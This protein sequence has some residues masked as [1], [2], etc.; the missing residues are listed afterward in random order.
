MTIMKVYITA[1]LTLLGSLQL[2]AQC[3]TFAGSPQSLVFNLCEGQ[4]FNVSTLGDEV[5]GGPCCDTLV[6]VVHTGGPVSLGTVIAANSAAGIPPATG[7]FEWSPAYQSGI[8]YQITAVAGLGDGNGPFG[9]NLTDPCLS[10]SPV[11]T[12]TYYPAPFVDAGPDLDLTCNIP[13]HVL[14]PVVTVIP[15]WQYSWTGP[16][17]FNSNLLHPTVNVPGN[18]CITVAD[19]ITG[20][21]ATD[22]M[23]VAGSVS[24]PVVQMSSTIIPC[25]G[26]PL[27]LDATGSSAGP[28][29]TYEWTQAGVGVVGTDITLTIPNPVPAFFQFI[30]TDT[31]TGCSNYTFFTTSEKIVADITSSDA[32]CEPG[33]YELPILIAVNDPPYL[34]SVAENGGAPVDY[35]NLLDPLTG[36]A[37]VPFQVNATT[38]FS[39]IIEDGSN[40][41]DTFF[42]TVYVHEGSNTFTVTQNGCQ[43]TTVEV[44]HQSVPAS[45]TIF[46][47]WST[48]GVGPQIEVTS[49]GWYTVSVT[50]DLGCTTVDSAFVEVDFTGQCAAI[51]G[52]VTQDSFANCLNDA[53][54]L[55]LA[56]WLVEAVGQDTF[57]ATTDATGFYAMPVDPGNYLVSV[58]PPT[59]LW[60]PCANGA[61]VDVPVAGDLETVDFLVQP[62]PGCLELLVNICTPF[63]RRCFSNY[64]FFSYCNQGVETATDAYVVVDLDDFMTFTS[65]SLPSSDLGNNQYQF[66]VGDLEPGECGAFWMEVFINCDAVLGQTHCTAA[67]IYPD[68]TCVPNDP[69]WS[70]ASLQVVAACADDSLRFTVTNVGTS[71]SMPLDFVVIEDAVMYME[72][73]PSPV[74]DVD[75]SFELA[76]PANGSTWRMEVQQEP[77]HP[78]AP[79]PV[80][81]VEGC[82]ENF[83]TGFINQFPLGDEPPYLDIDCT[84]N[85]GSY[86]PNDKQGFPV[87]YGDEHQVLPGTELQYLVRFQNTGTDTAFQVVIR[88]T[89]S[90]LLDVATV[91]PGA[92]SHPYQFEVYA[93][94]VLRFSFPD[95]LLPDSS[96][97]QA[98]S[99]GFVQFTVSPRADVPLG[100]V[101]ENTA[102]IYFD[103]NEPVITN[104]VFHT[105]DTNFLLANGVDF[106]AAGAKVSVSPNPFGSSVAVEVTG[107]QGSNLLTF[108]LSDIWGRTLAT[109]RFS[110][111]SFVF[112][113]SKL[114]VG[115]YFFKIADHGRTVARGRVMKG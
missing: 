70:G 36:M 111:P 115:M 34:I 90:S 27:V 89:L 47:Q 67:H 64:Y 87:G 35:S 82:G 25:D 1:I 59:A 16:N 100:S 6:F 94:G 3:T 104:T 62:L 28:S 41:V 39:I 114:P 14:Q 75:D 108:S 83:S 15:E 17:G 85:V 58:V 2:A 112:D 95:I 91:R 60:L 52:F 110:P 10:L 38:E 93:G 32:I 4:D 40:C 80:V 43:P 30:V 76:V 37:N 65:A 50:S 88:D 12:I 31:I 101:V 19:I 103:F 61:V 54:E 22:C 102:A 21:T 105:I 20:C 18:Y 29:F 5:F 7:H 33:S 84:E 107:H 77:F 68:T 69:L 57:Y 48:G 71:A 66:E 24:L 81:A 72:D 51:Q 46:A 74:L 92:A 26:S 106:V 78:L 79:A 23:V 55:P 45:Q 86:D 13:F 49:S 44:S 56:G 99:N 98:A 53:G 11:G 97:N 73:P 63:L 109:D 42:T 9:I 96:A 113:G 8:T